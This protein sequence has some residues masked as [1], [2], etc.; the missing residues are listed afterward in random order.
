VPPAASL[1]APGSGAGPRRILFFGKILPY[2]GVEDL[3]AAFAAVP[4]DAGATLLV[5]G[6]CDDAGLRSRLRALARA[7][8]QRVSLRLE[9]IADQDVAPLLT[10][11]DAIVLPYRA[12]TTSG[13]AMLALAYGRPLILP[14]LDAFA[15]LPREAIVSYDGTR[16]ALTSALTRVARAESPA[17]AGMAA[18]ARA[19]AAT[20]SWPDLAARTRSEMDS[21]MGRTASAER[22]GRPLSPGEA[23]PGLA[24]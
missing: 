7:G 11:A 4:A 17:L 13:S 6:E 18:A 3:L 10:S 12:V 21:I 19:Y 20:L 16:A 14:D 5:A 24:P 2:K 8:G 9:R 15:D 1:R 22:Q 23:V